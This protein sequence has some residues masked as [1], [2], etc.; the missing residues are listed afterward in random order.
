MKRNIVNDSQ[1][2][3]ELLVET[4]MECIWVFDLSA[5]KFLYISPS[6]F[7]L[8]G[9]TVEEAMKEKLEDCLTVRSL[10][11]LKNDSLRR[12]QRFIDG[13]RSNSIVYHLGDYEQY[14]KDG[15][16]KYIEISTRLELD[17]ATE[18]VLVVGVS[19]DITQRKLHEK[20]L[21]KTIRTQHKLMNVEPSGKNGE[22]QLFVYFFGKFR[23]CTKPHENPIKWRT[24]KTEELFAF[25]LQKENQY[26]SRDEILEALWPEAA[27]EKAIKLLYTTIYNLKTDL[28][29]T[30]V[31]FNLNL[32]NGFYFFDSQHF[33]SDLSEVRKLLNTS[34]NPYA[35]IDEKSA[36]DIEYAVILYQGDYLSENDYSWASA[37]R[38]FYR[39]QFEKYTFMLARYY[40]LRRDYRSTRR[41]LDMLIALDN[42]NEDYHE[43]LLNVFL[44]DDDYAGF[45]KH[46][47]DLLEMLQRELN[48]PPT[49]SIQTLYQQYRDYAQ[50]CIE[51]K[52]A[53]F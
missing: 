19:R 18:H 25:L 43:L 20:N 45:I 41:I 48:Q 14:C 30:N 29:K 11:K 33:Y 27:M 34:V 26:I 21:I 9:L 49:Q 38:A 15:S 8:R 31:C 16:I 36:R 51:K 22:F 17:T 32:T 47:N 13:D 52:R 35:E 10:Q 44:F 7:Q 3:F 28:K 24:S 50:I 23:V 53:H 6:I 40:F 1:L 12:Y 2:D 37:Q 42:L 46:Y 5:Q 4:L 39:R